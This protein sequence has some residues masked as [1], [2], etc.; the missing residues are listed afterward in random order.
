MNCPDDA[1]TLAVEF[2]Q[3]TEH[4]A[5]R[6]RGRRSSTRTGEL[7]PAIGSR[8]S[9]AACSMLKIDGSTSIKCRSR[10]RV[11]PEPIGHRAEVLEND[12]WMGS[13]GVGPSNSVATPGRIRDRDHD[14]PTAL[15][16]LDPESKP[17]CAEL[18]PPSSCVPGPCLRFSFRSPVPSPRGPST[19]T[20][21]PT[22]SGASLGE[23]SSRTRSGPTGR[24][25]APDSG[26]ATTSPKTSG[27]SLSSRSMKGNAGRRSTPR[28]S[29]RRSVMT[30]IPTAFLS[31]SLN[32]SRRTGKNAL[33]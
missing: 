25:T 20:D 9:R 31:I 27:S 8:R 6:A 24:P 4:R 13:G 14:D 12:P 32:G 26:T 29:P 23:R 28:H 10:P 21:G 16:S 22:P 17:P 33:P 3:G 7:S 19:I 2:D 5:D 18:V 1:A 15:A 11:N 30:P